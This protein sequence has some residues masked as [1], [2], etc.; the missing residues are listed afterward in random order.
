ML[1]I[2]IGRWFSYKIMILTAIKL[3]TYLYDSSHMGDTATD[4]LIFI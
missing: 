1:Y 3:F 4:K 2:A